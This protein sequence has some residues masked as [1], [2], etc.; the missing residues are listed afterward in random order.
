MLICYIPN[1][2]IQKILEQ[3]GKKNEKVKQNKENKM[4]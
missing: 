4:N 3:K 2:L 1:V